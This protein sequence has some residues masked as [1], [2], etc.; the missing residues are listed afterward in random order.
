MKNKFDIFIF[1]LFLLGY[2]YLLFHIK[3]V[4]LLTH[5]N[6]Y[7]L[8]LEIFLLIFGMGMLSFFPAYIFVIY[9]KRCLNGA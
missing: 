6:K 2:Y 5:A 1:I 7:I 8:L 4:N 9:V 3:L